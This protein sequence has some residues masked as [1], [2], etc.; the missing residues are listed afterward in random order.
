MNIILFVYILVYLP[1]KTILRLASFAHAILACGGEVM[2]RSLETSVIK[3]DIN[4]FCLEF[5]SLRPFV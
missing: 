4:R 3:C 1:T 5:S 2:F